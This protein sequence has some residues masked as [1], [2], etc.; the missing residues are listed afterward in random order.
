MN[1][2]S[3]RFRLTVW[4]AALLAL[5]LIIF[6]GGVYF[7][8]A[9]Y[10]KAKASDQ[11]ALQARQIA[12]TW[13]QRMDETGEEYVVDEIDEHL[14]PRATHRFIRLTRADG[15]V[16]YQSDPPRDGSFDP[17]MIPPASPPYREGMHQQ[18]L[19]GDVDLLIYAL[20]ASV[21]GA[22][23]FLIE[24]GAPSHEIERTLHGLAFTFVVILPLAMILA[25][26]SGYLLMK[27][28]LRPIDDITSAAESI[29]SRNLSER[30]PVPGT[31]DEVE[32]LS[33]TLNR[34]IERL[35]KSFRQV[36]QFTADAS[37][38][39]RTPLTI[40]RGELEVTLRQ[41]ELTPATREILESMLEE[42][43]RLS[44]TVEKLMMLSRL[45]SGQLKLER[46][47]FDLTELCQDTVE[48][49]RL[50]AED[51]E[52][53]LDFSAP[54]RLEVKA[55]PLRLRQ[56][57]INLIDN[58]IKYT[59]AG[60]SVNVTLA[61]RADRALIEVADTGQGIPADAIPHIFDRFYRVDEARSRELGG[62]WLGIGHH[63]D[64]V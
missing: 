42:T 33:Q 44:E 29:T 63:Q 12:E 25:I 58:A 16:L 55:D 23:T 27:R 45:D 30:L 35:E 9:R 41:N 59:P 4:Y 20:P 15:S 3:I 10:L 22:G 61:Q 48:Q 47:W 56:I 11:L 31:G 39:L 13:L 7:G 1:V 18:H 37:H 43:D 62:E 50:L 6:G 2:H 49:M 19:P 28:A 38:E 24:V 54:A 46:Q 21:P 5:M 64:V 26:G 8:L 36:T 14:S 34:M 32:R 53:R 40:L 60:G 17:S 57:L 52:L 51:K